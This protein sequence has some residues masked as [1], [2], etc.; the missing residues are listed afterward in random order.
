MLRVL[1]DENMPRSFTHLLGDEDIQAQTVGQRGWKGRPDGALLEI[2]QQEFDV[3]ITTD[4]GIPHQQNLSKFTLGI[5]LIKAR[6][7][8]LADLKPLAD[9]VKTV[10]Q[11]IS[12][13][14]LLT[15]SL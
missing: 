1:L 5:I 9:Q 3:F 6:S 13:G 4:Q 12:G 10:I 11:Q 8:R 15:V 7:N 2:A 14:Q